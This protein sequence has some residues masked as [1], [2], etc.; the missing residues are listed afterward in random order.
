MPLK[1]HCR[2]DQIGARGWSSENTVRF[3][4]YSLELRESN[5]VKKRPDMMLVLIAAFGLGVLLTVTLPMSS[6]SSNAAPASPLQAG[7]IDPR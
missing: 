1:I 6:G 2:C 4:N 3:K 5:S 7:I